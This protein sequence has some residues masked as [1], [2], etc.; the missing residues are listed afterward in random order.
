[1]FV[2]IV[3][4]CRNSIKIYKK[5]WKIFLLVT[6]FGSLLI[7]ALTLIL[8]TG[9]T[10]PAFAVQLDV[11]LVPKKDNAKA[12]YKSMSVIYIEYPNGGKLQ[13]LLQNSDDK[14]VFTA[15]KDTPGVQE[16]ISK[17]N[18]NLVREKISPVIVED[19]KIDYKAALKTND[20]RAT[21]EHNLKLGITI[22]GFALSSGS[23][24]EGALIDLNWRGLFLDQPVVLTTEQYGDVEINFP[25][26]YYYSKNPEVM[27][28][29]EN[30]EGVKLINTPSIDF[31]EL[32]NAPIDKWEWLF[33]PTGS[34]TESEQFGFTEVEGADLITFFAYGASSVE[35]GS[36]VS[37]EKISRTDV[38][39][40]NVQYTIRKT[41]PPSS[42]SIQITGYATES[43]QGSDEGALVFDF[44]PEG[45]GKS[46]AGG[47]PIVVV[48][49]LGGMM[50]V[51]AIF[52]LWRANKK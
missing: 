27:R 21:L 7:L 6:R 5:E 38:T 1:M 16:L 48:G 43:I 49:A 9:T 34:I 40:D 52:V 36:D 4:N 42:A 39:I 13:T 8:I 24:S 14:I 12:F 45:A 10:I 51:V 44:V 22:T 11:L 19:I 29:L 2:L 46:Y 25:S 35:S 3:K 26:G 20:K 28:T 23:D 33:D 31:R 30:T 17:M 32:T 50:A 47:F 37:R 18:N 41:S 15:D